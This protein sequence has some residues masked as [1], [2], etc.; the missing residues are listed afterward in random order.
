MFSFFKSLSTRLSAVEDLLAKV[1]DQAAGMIEEQSGRIEALEK[2]Q[3][4]SDSRMRLLKNEWE[5]VLDR[6]N[7]VMG[8][9]NARIRKSEAQNDVVSDTDVG[10]QGAPPTGTHAALVARRGR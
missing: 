5:D 9:L 4:A 2:A 7:R 10:P 8:R 3:E 1:V 6:A